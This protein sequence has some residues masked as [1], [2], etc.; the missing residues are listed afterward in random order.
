MPGNAMVAVCDVLGFGD[1]IKC[2]SLDDAIIYLSS[3]Q[4]LANKSPLTGY[5]P[6]G[7]VQSYVGHMHFSD[8]V[9]FYSLEDNIRAFEHI[10]FSVLRFLAIPFLNPSYRFRIGIS[11]GEFF[12][13]NPKHVYVGKA[14][15]DAYE[16][17]K[18]QEW[19]GAA[20]S[21]AAFDKVAESFNARYYLKEYYVPIKHDKKETYNV[22]N[23]TLAQHKPIADERFLE[24]DYAIP[25][26]EREKNIELKLKN[27]EQ[28]HSDVCVQCRQFR[29]Q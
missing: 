7:D 6:E 19:C 20:L 16:L 4:D 11:Y 21:R 2:N 28:F 15:V 24:R 18:K 3:I 22:V 29:K 26:T 5:T 14:L 23:W 25:S 12:Y 8:T 27:T 17:Q 10:I 13:D 9:V 1:Y